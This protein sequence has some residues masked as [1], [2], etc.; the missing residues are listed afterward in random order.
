[1]SRLHNNSLFLFLVPALL[2]LIVF[3]LLPSLWAIY[4]SFTDLALAGPKAMNYGFIG[5]RNYVE[6]FS[7]RNFH[8][9]LWLSIQYTVYTNIG[10]F[11]LGL[12]AALILSR[13]KLKGQN[14]LLAVIVLPMVIPGITQALIWSSMFGAGELGTLNRQA[15]WAH[16]TASS[17]SLAWS[18]SYG[19]ALRPCSRLCSSTSGTMPAL[20]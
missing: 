2:L 9:S 4:I 10:Q 13:R 11:V 19:C 18:R 7:D 15:N 1:M 8:N 20:P 14:F 17:A 12:S 6:L 5:L 3:T 16:S